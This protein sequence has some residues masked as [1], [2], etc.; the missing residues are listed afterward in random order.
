MKQQTKLGIGLTVAALALVSG[1]AIAGGSVG[2]GGGS[3]NQV[4][5]RSG[6]MQHNAPGGSVRIAGKGNVAEV[7]GRGSQMPAVTTTPLDATAL[8]IEHFGRASA[9]EAIVRARPAA[10]DTLAQAK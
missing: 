10:S 7:S 9:P 6:A 3:V 4:F 1:T 5:G 2:A 8:G